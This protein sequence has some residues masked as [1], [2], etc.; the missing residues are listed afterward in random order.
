MVLPDICWHKAKMF[1]A[2]TRWKCY[3]CGILSSYSMRPKDVLI[4]GFVCLS[5]ISIVLNANSP[6][7]FGSYM[8]CSTPTTLLE[9]QEIKASSNKTMGACV[10]VMDE[11]IKL[12]EFIAYHCKY[13][14]FS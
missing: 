10:F 2:I 8:P 13:V 5:V 11:R 1:G 6:V 3:F 9:S 7:M 12:L 4:R 14:L